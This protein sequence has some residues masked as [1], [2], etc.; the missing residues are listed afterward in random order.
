M[1]LTIHWKPQATIS[2]FLEMDFI[3]SKWNIIEVQKFENLVDEFLKTLTL[4][5]EMGKYSTKYNCHSIVISRQTTL[6]YKIL[7]DK[8]QLDLILFWNNTK[9]PTDL[10]KLL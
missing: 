8:N 10:T 6:F 5:P 1:I 9:N 3:L 4:K 2:Y 7:K